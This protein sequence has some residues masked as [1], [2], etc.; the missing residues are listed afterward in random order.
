[1]ASELMSIT[2][3][4]FIP[5]QQ[6]TRLVP[7]AKHF[8]L[9]RFWRLGA[10]FITYELGH[11]GV[12]RTAKTT[13]GRDGDDQFVGVGGLGRF[14]GAGLVVERLREQHV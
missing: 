4:I 10:E 5:L 14:D 3:T 6:C 11:V 13:I 12:D 2:Y 1:M 9:G 7:D 8:G